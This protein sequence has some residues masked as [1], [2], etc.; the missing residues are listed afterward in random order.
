MA[1]RWRADGGPFWLPGIGFLRD[2]GTDPL[3]PFEKKYIKRRQSFGPG[4]PRENL[5][6]PRK[7][8][9]MNTVK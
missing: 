9:V 6:Y 5:L 1:L 8:I 3:S 4:L 7:F 2:T